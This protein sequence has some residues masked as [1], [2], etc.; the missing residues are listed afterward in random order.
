MRCRQLT[1]LEIHHFDN[2]NF[3]LKLHDLIFFFS[4]QFF[5]FNLL[6]LMLNRLRKLWMI[7]VNF[8][9][10]E[11]AGERVRCKL[12]RNSSLSV[13]EEP[14]STFLQIIASINDWTRLFTLDDL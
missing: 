5:E 3:V 9:V 8:Y 11:I 1:K 10:I 14:K 13:L 7:R 4:N 2:L 12:D 6:K